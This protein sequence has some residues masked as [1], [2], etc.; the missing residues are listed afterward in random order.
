PPSV[1]SVTGD[2]TGLLEL[3]VGSIAG[4]G[5]CVA[6]APDGRVVF[7][8]HSLP[9]ERVVATVTSTTSSFIRADA[10]DVLRSSPDRVDPPC[11]Y[12]G[13]GRCGGCDFRHIAPA[14]PRRLQAW[15]VS[16]QLQRLA[17][18]E[19]PVEVEAVSGDQNGLGWRTR[20]RLGVDQSG[21][22]GFRR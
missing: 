1:R 13:P 3:D 4:G 5:G 16:E 14:A 2:D 18:L 15:R 10:T 8:R 17:G 11:P 20:V 22:L 7:V 9:G 19:R 12:A 6:H 21:Q